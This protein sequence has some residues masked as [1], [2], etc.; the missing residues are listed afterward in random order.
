MNPLQEISNTK[1]TLSPEQE[2][3]YKLAL[4]QE[5][6]KDDFH[7]FV[8]D[9]FQEAFGVPY[10]PHY[11]TQ[12]ACE[13]IE[14]N[15]RGYYQWGIYNFPRGWGKSVFISV[16]ASAWALLRDPTERIGCYSRALTE[17]AKLWHNQAHDILNLDFT[18][19][20]VNDIKTEYNAYI[21]KTPQKGYRRVGSCLSSSVGS[22]LTLAIIDDPQTQDHYRSPAKRQTL[23]NFFING[24]LRAIRTVDYSY[25]NSDFEGEYFQQLTKSQ[26]NDAIKQARLTEELQKEGVVKTKEPRLMIA[27]QRLF[28][29][30]FCYIVGD[31]I[32]KMEEAGVKMNTTW[33][34]IPSIQEKATTYVFPKSGIVYN[35][36]QGAYT[37]AGTL[38]QRKILQARSQMSLKDF[39]AQ[40]QGKPM[41][42]DSVLM[43]RSMF[44]RYSQEDLDQ[45]FDDVFITVDLAYTDN[46]KSDYSVI[47]VWGVNKLRNLYL[48]DLH[49]FKGRG[50][51]YFK[52][53]EAVHQIWNN[54]IPNTTISGIYLEKSGNA[55]TLD[56]M[57][58]SNSPFSYLIKPIP[59]TKS[60]ILR[61]YEVQFVICNA[62]GKGRVYLPNNDM[63]I[64]NGGLAK[65]FV[66]PFL[67]ECEAF[68]EEA[69]DYENDDMVDTLID[70]C[71]IL[72]TKPQF[73]M[74]FSNIFG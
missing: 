68:T 44:N 17:D 47:A 35:S 52:K 1:T 43:S 62:D 67:D 21:F 2:Y 58:H 27:M 60:K 49:R 11:T 72:S 39:N 54:A 74:N 34:N 29:K 5:F 12:L 65:A 31:I 66:E 61:F 69:S 71:Y 50:T 30:D 20:F 55:Q 13:H 23:E 10:K 45:P 46:K 57:E 14:Y 7:S 56:I 19:T 64:R 24:L 32:Q 25:S 36:P 22:D 28:P 41:L 73:N 51:A 16:L 37:E 63:I 38:T 40:M 48:L 33:I 4:M 42:A 70:S 53:L 18:K 9:V 6:Y 15:I 59:R 3:Q 8:K 26:K